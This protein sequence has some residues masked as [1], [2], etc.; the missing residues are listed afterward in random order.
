MQRAARAALVFALRENGVLIGLPFAR[1]LRPDRHQRIS[2]TDETFATRDR[3]SVQRRT[4]TTDSGDRRRKVVAVG[5]YS[6]KRRN[7]FAGTG[8]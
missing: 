2:D 5:R 6:R 7:V 3:E 4:R 1:A 8:M